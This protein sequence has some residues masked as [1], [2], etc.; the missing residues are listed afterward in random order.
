MSGVRDVVE[1]DDGYILRDA[2]AALAQRADC[3]HRHP[4]VHREYG[5]QVGAPV[6]QRLGG[7]VSALV[8]V[9]TGRDQGFIAGNRL[10]PQG[11]VV[12]GDA[13]KNRPLRYPDT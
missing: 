10:R 12:A 6:E 13:L 9:I 2:H 8:R 11:I 3:A 4:V 7:G 1:P 5:S